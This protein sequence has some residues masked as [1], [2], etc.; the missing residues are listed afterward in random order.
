MLLPGAGSSA[1]FVS[2]AFRR[3][4]EAAGY[5]LVAGAPTPGP[6]VVEA[7]F[8]ILDAARRAYGPRLGIVGGVS[9]GAHVAARWAASA[10]TDPDCSGGAARLDGLLLALPAWTG[11]PGVV[12]AATAAAAGE[13]ARLG[14]TEALSRAARA[15]VPWVA[16]ELAA[17]WP[18]Y[19]DRLAATLQAAAA[20]CGPAPDELGSL[21]LPVGVVS[22]VDD[23]LHPLAVGERWVALLPRA[24]L[25]RLRLAD[26]A[27]DRSV[28]G[29]AALR[30][31]SR[32]A[33][34]A[35]PVAPP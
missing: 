8:G 21:D 26:L 32:V 33:P 19:G 30:A 24:T 4:L 29:S 6:A 15:G 35:V 1:D 28:L 31:L 25:A 12:A 5:E 3:P 7:A 22:F 13:V 17:A 18:G 34:G 23:P 10:G 16:D 2:R 11:T 27:P 14:V 20:S 9:L